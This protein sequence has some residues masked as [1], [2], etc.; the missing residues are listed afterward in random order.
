MSTFD[1]FIKS[2]PSI[3][4]HIESADS[5]KVEF[6]K[7][8]PSKSSPFPSY[9]IS[10]FSVPERFFFLQI[11]FIFCPVELFAVDLTVVG[12]RGTLLKQLSFFADECVPVELSGNAANSNGNRPAANSSYHGPGGVREGAAVAEPTAGCAIA[13]T[14]RW[15]VARGV[16]RLPQ[17]W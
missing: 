17:V 13:D 14:A 2:G 10:V 1:I 8:S 3:I 9:G 11:L 12:Y 16:R 4:P 6:G 5:Y 15:D 7:F